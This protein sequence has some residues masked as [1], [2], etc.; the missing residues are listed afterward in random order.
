MT[1][2]QAD[3]AANLARIT[4][5]IRAAEAAAG[6][7][8]G[9]TR[10]IAVSKVQPVEKLDAALAAGQRLFGENRVQEAKAKF[11]AARERYPDIELH[12]IGPLQTN[13]VKEAVA[14]FDVIQTLD[15][16]KL[17]AALAEEGRKRGHLPRLYVEVNVGAEPQK[18]GIA[19][20]DLEAFLRDC[21]EV[22]GLS[23][24]GLMCIPPADEEPAPYF[25]LLA[26]LAR[27]LG[28][29]EISMG[30]SGDYELATR[31]GATMVRVG[32]AIFGERLK[33]AAH[34]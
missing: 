20:A 33:P 6:R 2:L 28:L 9:A 17:A 10:L 5:H 7:P 24:E 15:R 14:L 1:D 8:A 22:H 4:A 26:D 13:K 11:P 31:L 30:M 25:A 32:T 3:I 29:K 12:L 18:A 21:R 34:E 19:P 23:I 27:R 16:P